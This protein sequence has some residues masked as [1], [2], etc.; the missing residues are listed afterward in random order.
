MRSKKEYKNRPLAADAII[1]KNNKILLVKR[2]HEPFKG[3]YAL[4]GGFVESNETTEEAVAREVMEETNLAVKPEK[5][6]GVYSNSSRD[7]RQTI[8]ICY[9]CSFLRGNLHSGDDALSVAWFSLDKLTQNLAFDHRLMI[10][11]YFNLLKK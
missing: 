9:Q 6:I 3:Y 8:S 11:D 5:I 7:P 1:I 10:K 2:K 4:P